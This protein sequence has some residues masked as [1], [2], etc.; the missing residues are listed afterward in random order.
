VG[1]IP[2]TIIYDANGNRTSFSPYGTTDSYTIND[3]SQYTS[4]NTI[5]AAYNLNGD[6]TTG[7]DGSSYTY[8]AQNRLLTANN[9]GITETFK[10][11]G[12]NR[13]VSRTVQLSRLRGIER[14]FF[15]CRGEDG[16]GGAARPEPSGTIALSTFCRGGVGAGGG[17]SI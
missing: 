7:V 6:L 9:S 2:R 8:D 16:V 3:L 13:Q 12:L 15:V 5:N 10:Y 4:R 17:Q 14:T 11:D 1:S